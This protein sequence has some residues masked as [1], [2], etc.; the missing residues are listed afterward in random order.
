M[1]RM[2]L[3]WGEWGSVDPH[4]LAIKNL[5]FAVSDFLTILACGNEEATIGGCAPAAVIS[6]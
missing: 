4:L 1:W 6:R 3:N 5:L 2:W